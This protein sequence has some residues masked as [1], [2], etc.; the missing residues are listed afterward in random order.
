MEELYHVIPG[1]I[2]EETYGYWGPD[3]ARYNADANSVPEYGQDVD[4][5]WQEGIFYYIEYRDSA[6]IYKRTYYLCDCVEV[7]GVIAPT[8]HTPP[9]V[10]ECFYYVSAGLTPALNAKHNVYS[11]PSNSVDVGDVWVFETVRLIAVVGN[12]SLID[13]DLSDAE[14]GKR[15][16]AW[17]ESSKITALPTPTGTVYAYTAGSLEDEVGYTAALVQ[18]AANAQFIYEYLTT[19]GFTPQAACGVLGN[20]YQ[21]C[22]MNPALWD[23]VTDGV[24]DITEAYGIFQ[25]DDATKYLNRAVS[26]G[27]ISTPTAAAINYF[28]NQNVDDNE[29]ADKYKR[30]LLLS[31]L[32]YML[33][34]C[35]NDRQW[36]DP[37][38]YDHITDSDDPANQIQT[39]Y[40]FMTSTLDSGTLAIV[41][42]DFFEKSG[43][44]DDVYHTDEGEPDEGQGRLTKRRD[45]A[46][47]YY[48]RIVLGL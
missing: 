32:E 11:G 43:D 44:F 28:T 10:P 45:S 6:N 37:G 17:I 39:I 20:I 1:R 18:Q 16:R 9:T 38:E 23:V 35:I 8:V 47:D 30:I 7:I 24:P 48:N 25:W 4:I 34:G 2:T 31:Q 27:L 19:M 5:L 3:L 26:H 46:I 42:H 22:T 13:F 41:F 14:N 29:R 36:C 33:W 15:K 12:Y 21:E 40:Q